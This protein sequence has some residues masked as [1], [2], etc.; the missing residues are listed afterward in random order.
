MKYYSAQ[1]GIPLR[2]DPGAL[3]RNALRS[4]ARAALHAARNAGKFSLEKHP[5]RDDRAIEGLLTRSPVA[6]TRTSDVAALMQV[7]LHFIASLVPASAAAAVLNET[8]Q[9]SFD[10]AYSIS[11]PGVSLPTAGWIGEAQAIPVLQGTTSSATL[12][13]SKP[14]CIVV[15][16][17]EMTDSAD[18]ETIMERV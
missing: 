14:A 5:W 10:G 4:V 11:I 15:L 13:P 8:V 2:P 18:A 17:R 6:P 7:K 16:T 1:S 12:S 9:A 3:T